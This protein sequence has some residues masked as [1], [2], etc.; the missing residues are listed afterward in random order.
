[1]AYNPQI[2]VI[3]T[4]TLNSNFSFVNGNNGII[5][6]MDNDVAF[7]DDIE[8]Q[9]LYAAGTALFTITNTKLVPDNDILI[10]IYIT[11]IYGN[12]YALCEIKNTGV[13]SIK[14]SYFAPIFH[15]NGLQYNIDSNY[16]SPTLG[17]LS[18]YTTPTDLS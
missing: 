15:F 1:M 2:S 7:C 8:T 14:N 11:S 9:S 17:N 10:P 13:V 5:M 12:E 3:D 16:F 4:I 6:S 18:G